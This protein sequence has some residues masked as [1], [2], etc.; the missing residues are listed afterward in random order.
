MNY[1]VLGITAAIVIAYL[2]V[3]RVYNDVKEGRRKL[4]ELDLGLKIS[5]QTNKVESA[6]KESTEKL[7]EYRAAKALYK[8]LTSKSKPKS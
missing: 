2:Y 8:S 6:K 3:R 7:E 1:Q 5:K 4:A